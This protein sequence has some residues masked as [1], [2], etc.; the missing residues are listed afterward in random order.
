MKALAV[1]DVVVALPRLARERRRIQAA[2]RIDATMFAAALTAELSSPYLGTLRR[3]VCLVRAL[4][5]YWSLV[6]SLLR[7]S[8]RWA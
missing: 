2:R 3:K 1:L 6:R 4:S 7:T 8:S 5:L